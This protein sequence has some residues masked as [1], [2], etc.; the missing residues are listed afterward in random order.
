MKKGYI[1]IYTGNGKGKT[2]A[3]LGLALRA[4][5]RGL[6]VIM[7]QFLKGVDS[8]E[9][10]SA[11]RL[12]PEFTIYRFESSHKFIS[13]MSDD[14]LAQLRQDISRGFDFSKQVIQGNA[15]DILILDEIMAAIHS[16]FINVSEVVELMRSKPD[17]IEL[18][19]TGRN[20]PDE[21]ADLADLI[22]EM[23]PIKHYYDKGV[24][25]RKGIEL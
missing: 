19:L 6:K 7:I 16:G 10:H 3:A 14:E 23:K 1:Q 12:A 21:I 18:V 25:A 17:N 15:C 9:L 13:D 20:V 5:G 8:G 11:Q 4:V 22:T 2:T 24:T